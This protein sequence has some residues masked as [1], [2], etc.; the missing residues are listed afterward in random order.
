VR[1]LRRQLVR[2]W[3]ALRCASGDDAYER[4]LSHQRHHHPHAA[5]LSAGAFYAEAQQR[6][7]G[8]VSRCC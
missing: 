3:A 7:W 2:A 8:G 4:Y 6:K 1:R 5:P